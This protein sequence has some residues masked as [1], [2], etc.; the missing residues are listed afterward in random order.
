MAKRTKQ[1]SFRV[2]E[3][4]Y[5][6]IKKIVDERGIKL[7]RFM[8]DCIKHQPSFPQKDF[9]DLI[10][11][12]KNHRTNLK[13]LVNFYTA[14]QKDIKLTNVVIDNDDL[15]KKILTASDLLIKTLTEETKLWPLL[16]V[17]LRKKH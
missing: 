9:R 2:T 10:C 4:E 7:Q 8:L 13:R 11:E 15:F 6:S 5:N 1:I 12:M 3:D 14:I 16:N 17:Y